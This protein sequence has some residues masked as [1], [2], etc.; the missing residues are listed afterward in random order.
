MTW[1]DRVA[2]AAVFVL[3]LVLRLLVLAQLSDLPL[4]RTPQLDSLEYLE[5][6]SRIAAGDFSWPET[7][8]HGPGYPMFLGGALAIARSLSGARVVQAFAGSVTALLIFLIASRLHGRR[9]AIVAGVLAACYAPLIFI[10]VS[11]FGEGLLVL[12]LTLVAYLTVRPPGR[13][14]ALV[15]ALAGLAFGFAITVR[16]TALVLAPLFLRRPKVL[17][18]VAM[19]A[20]PIVPVLVHN[21]SASGDVVAL[22][23]SGGMN[24][25]IGNSPKHDGT[26]WARPGGEWDWLRGSAWR[27]GH[28]APSDQDRFYVDQAFR[29]I[30]AQPFRYARLIA[31]KAL[32]LV[33][34]DEIR[35]SH[36]FRFFELSSPL[37]RWLPG[38]GLVFAFAA[39]GLVAAVRQREL[40]YVVTGWIVLASAALMLLVI[41]VRYRMPLVP[42][43][44]V[45]AGV[46]V[47]ALW[48]AAAN[49]Q[50]REVVTLGGIALVAFALTHARDHHPT[51]DLTEERAMN[52][53]ALLKEGN[54]VNARNAAVRATELGPRSALAWLTLGDIEASRG[55]WT[56]AEA[57]WRRAIACDARTA[58]A[59]SHLALAFIRRGD[60]ANAERALR[61]SISIK[62]EAE[63][64][65]NLERLRAM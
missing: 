63:A 34:S 4:F 43:L 27:N 3:A 33:Q 14:P 48:R 41:G 65:A 18:F 7:P 20:Y 5:W 1:R 19:A 38:F 46:G 9:A 57:A 16:P 11:I 62:P 12:L 22:Q 2:P 50:R 40:S 39:A 28:R 24:F 30:E 31:A 29:E 58:R 23:A 53:L 35:D 54:I 51:H 25:Y 13:R 42:P 59:W 56:A 55:S 36:S 10:D 61:R 64:L 52:A 26:A 47:D 49:R 15:A 32:W 60:G 44:L 17:V 8:I 45:F 37:L 6:A 21:W